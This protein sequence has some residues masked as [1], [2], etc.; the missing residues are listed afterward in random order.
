MVVHKVDIELLI[1]KFVRFLVIFDTPPNPLGGVRV[2]CQGLF[3][4]ESGAKKSDEM[5][6]GC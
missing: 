3:C 1:P 5:D 4:V 2:T 6:K